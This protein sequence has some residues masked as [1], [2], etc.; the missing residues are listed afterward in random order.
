MAWRKVDGMGLRTVRCRR[1]AQS[2][3]VWFIVMALCTICMWAQGSVVGI[4]LGGLS[5]MLHRTLVFLRW[6]LMLIFP[7]FTTL[8]LYFMNIAA[9][10]LFQGWSTEMSDPVFRLSRM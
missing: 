1:S 9:Q 4:V 6:P 3:F 5:G 8:T 7:F 2:D 10:L